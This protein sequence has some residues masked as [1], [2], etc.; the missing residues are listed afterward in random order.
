M[1][2]L[3]TALSDFSAKQKK[4]LVDT[5]NQGWL[6]GAG[7]YVPKGNAAQANANQ[8]QTGALSP[9]GTANP[10]TGPDP[11]RQYGDQ[12]HG[13]VST[14][15]HSPVGDAAGA[16]G[17]GVVVG[18]VA[19]SIPNA[20][21]RA[22]AL[23]P[24][25]DGINSMMAR[26]ATY[27]P[28]GQ[29]TDINTAG[30]L[31]Q[32]GVQTDASNSM[33][34]TDT[35]TPIQN[36]FFDALRAWCDENAWRLDAG[37]SVAWAG[38]QAGYAEAADADGQLLEWQTEDDGHVCFPAGTLVTTERG[39]V[40]IETIAAGERVLTHEGRWR[41]VL[42]RM[43]QSYSGPMV[44]I[45]TSHTV[46]STANHPFLIQ[47]GDEMFWRA[48]RDLKVGDVVFE[49]DLCEQCGHVRLESTLER[50][51]A[52]SNN[53]VALADEEGITTGVESHPVF[54]RVPVRAVYFHHDVADY[55]VDAV[56]TDSDLLLVSNAEI[57]KTEAHVAL[58]RRLAGKA[59]PAGSVA[60]VVTASPSGSNAE[61]FAAG[62]AVDVDRW[63]VA[64]LRAVFGR[65]AQRLATALTGM[66]RQSRGRP[67]AL[68]RAVA[69]V[70]STGAVDGE[71]RATCDAFEA[72]RQCLVSAPSGAVDLSAGISR[73]HHLA[74]VRARSHR[75]IIVYNL[76][77]EDDHSYVADGFA[78]H[79][80]DDCQQL[81]EMPPQALADW[82]CM[83]GD[84]TTA[85]NVGC[86]C[87]LV[88]SDVD[89]A[90]NDDY[91]PQLSPAQQAVYNTIMT[92]QSEAMMAA[93][94]DAAYLQ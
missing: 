65:S 19:P 63:S 37:S 51:G 17:G 57:L 7:S 39:V 49:Q 10:T 85:C 76:E 20:I 21:R 43:A 55:E 56:S 79:N 94:P 45:E 44:T 50:V 2:P 48:A 64:D 84:G 5:Y 22:V 29:D 67:T 61:P 30:A 8:V 3:Q 31:T 16:F 14:I 70:D 38:E 92:R 33:D 34:P 62:G 75:S 32:Q 12:A 9:G 1:I 68:V 36:G 71:G 52:K 27:Y 23:R 60:E 89:P 74:A 6:Q 26:L 80:C 77:V 73:A 58:R 91:Q 66:L 41:E 69:R 46:T 87:S 42:A 59:T 11:D 4:L 15:A 13:P 18:Y 40:P 24:A 47:V 25:Y 54:T 53:A 88:A 78:V 90:D 81:G 86:R 28:P 82:P 83:P 35:S 72:D 93:M